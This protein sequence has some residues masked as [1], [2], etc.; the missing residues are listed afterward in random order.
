MFLWKSYLKSLKH[1]VQC[2]KTIHHLFEGGDVSQILPV[3]QHKALV[4]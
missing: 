1:R 2:L 3:M 4:N